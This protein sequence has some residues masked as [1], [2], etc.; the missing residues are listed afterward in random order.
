LHQH[1]LTL[2]DVDDDRSGLLRTVIADLLAA[3]FRVQPLRVDQRDVEGLVGLGPDVPGRIIILCDL[4][5]PGLTGAQ[6]CDQREGEQNP[7]GHKPATRCR[8][9]I[10]VHQVRH[11]VSDHPDMRTVIAPVTM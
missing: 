5:G 8:A 4:H 2:V 3:E 7:W 1:E 11:A 9:L 6:R 10:R